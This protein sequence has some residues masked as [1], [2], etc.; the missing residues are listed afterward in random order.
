M[1]PFRPVWHGFAFSRTPLESLAADYCVRIPGRQFWRY[2]LAGER[3]GV[4]WA[5]WSREHLAGAGEWLEYQD[6]GARRYRAARLLDG[7]LQACLFVGPTH[8]LPT[9]TWLAQ[10][11]AATALD[12][13]ARAS[14]LTARPPADQPDAGP[15]LCSCFG[16]GRNV[17]IAAIQRDRL[18]TPE[19]VGAALLAGTNCGSCVPELRALIDATLHPAVATL[20]TRG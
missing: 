6:R 4:D 19:A 2:E 13:A 20:V 14:L 15:T 5:A 18:T 17:L 9:R 3:D 16:V 1:A 10:L 7:R 11:F 8:D 12:G